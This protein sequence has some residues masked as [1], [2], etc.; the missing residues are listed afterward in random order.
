MATN[1]DGLDPL[2]DEVE[3]LRAELK[4]V[5]EGGAE[6]KR[7]EEIRLQREA[8]EKE[9]ESL[10]REIDYEKQAAALLVKSGVVE[11]EPEVKSG[12]TT[13]SVTAPSNVPAFTFNKSE[14]AGEE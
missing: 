3:A 12:F 4:D 13:A 5:R 7:K 11:A 9:R 14:N 8:L 1:P 10:L 2:R 6:A